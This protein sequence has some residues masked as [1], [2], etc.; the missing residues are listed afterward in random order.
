MLKAEY[1]LQFNIIPKIYR[2]LQEGNVMKFYTIIILSLMLLML[3]ITGCSHSHNQ[4]SALWAERRIDDDQRIYEN[5]YES[6]NRQYYIQFHTT[7]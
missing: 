3:M 4:V 7:Y 5:P 6:L 2:K 1:Y